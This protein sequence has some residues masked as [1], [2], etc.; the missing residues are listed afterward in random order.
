METPRAAL[1]VLQKVWVFHNT[2]EMGPHTIECVCSKEECL[3]MQRA[4]RYRSRKYIDHTAC[5]GLK[6]G[7][8]IKLRL[9]FGG[10]RKASCKL[11]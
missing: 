8:R 1:A 9:E 2:H 4:W 6:F 7:P 5:A 11:L 10:R 3:K